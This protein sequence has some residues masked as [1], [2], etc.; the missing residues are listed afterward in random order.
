METGCKVFRRDVLENL[1]IEEKRFGFE[2]DI[3]A[4]FYEV[5]IAY[6]RGR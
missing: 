4:R 5:G 3:T 6:L 2:P 1:R